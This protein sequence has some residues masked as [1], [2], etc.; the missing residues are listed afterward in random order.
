MTRIPRT[1]ALGHA[2][3]C[4]SLVGLGAAGVFGYPA[5]SKLGCEMFTLGMLEILN[6]ST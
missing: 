2:V 3:L 5:R 4:F 1:N 6:Q